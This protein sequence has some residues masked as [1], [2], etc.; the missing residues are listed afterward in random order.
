MGQRGLA[1]IRTGDRVNRAQRVV[2]A[3]HVTLGAG[4]TAFGCLHGD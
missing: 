3:A 1:A 4:G 2:S